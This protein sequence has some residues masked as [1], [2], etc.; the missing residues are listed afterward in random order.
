MGRTAHTLWSVLPQTLAVHF[1]VD[2]SLLCGL[3]CV[4]DSGFYP[5]KTSTPS[6]PG[7]ACWLTECAL[8]LVQRVDKDIKQGWPQYWAL[9]NTTRDQLPD[10]C[11]YIH[12]TLG[13]AIHPVF[14]IHSAMKG[15]QHWRYT[16]ILKAE[17]TSMNTEDWKYSI[18][19]FFFCFFFFI[20]LFL[21]T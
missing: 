3:P 20:F 16:C 21:K 7:V 13:L 11:D 2:I 17:T 8:C 19:F 6:Q 1:G 10:G 18:F 14:I 4:E 5:Q 9:G 12:S 15:A